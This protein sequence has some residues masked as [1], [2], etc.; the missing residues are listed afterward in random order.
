MFPSHIINRVVSADVCG[1]L[2][3]SNSPTGC[4]KSSLGIV[5][6]GQADDASCCWCQNSSFGCLSVPQTS[7]EEQPV[8]RTCSNAWLAGCCLEL[9]SCGPCCPCTVM[10]LDV[11]QLD[12][13]LI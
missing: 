13:H 9:L 10:Q 2:L 1:Q 4:S 6:K 3:A 7:G 11:M 12:M 5:E 8:A